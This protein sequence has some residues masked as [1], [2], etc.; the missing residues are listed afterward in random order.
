MEN[1]V[2]EAARKND[3]N[4]KD[5]IK[6]ILAIDKPINLESPGNAIIFAAQSNNQEMVRAILS[7]SCLSSEEAEILRGKAL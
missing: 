5:S 6:Q 4:A 1:A 2:K 7:R 3:N